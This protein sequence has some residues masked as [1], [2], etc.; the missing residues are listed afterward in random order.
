LQSHEQL[1]VGQ[2]Q[3]NQAR[4]SNEDLRGKLAM[5][6]RQSH[7]VI[8]AGREQLAL[9]EQTIEHAREAF[10][11]TRKRFTSHLADTNATQ[12]SMTLDSLE[13]AYRSYIETINNYNKAQL[14]LLLLLDG[15]GCPPDSL[16]KAGPALRSL[17]AA[18]VEKQ[19]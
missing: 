11:R 14:Q 4:L 17:P 15:H 9:L 13:D 18:I 12:V 7:A 1:R 5:G 6:V 3:T 10:T 19:E 2:S 16:A 8:V